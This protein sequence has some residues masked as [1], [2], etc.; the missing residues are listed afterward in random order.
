MRITR[1]LLPIALS[2]LPAAALTPPEPPGAPA[3]ESP[4]SEAERE[5]SEVFPRPAALEPRVRF[6]ARV[7][8]E[9][10]TDGGLLH[11]PDD[12]SLVYEVVR[13]PGVS[14]GS[15][16]RRVEQAK[17]RWASVLRSLASGKR[18]R[19]TPDEQ[20]ALSLFPPGVTSRR[21]ADAAR[22]VRFQLGQADK[23]RAGIVRSGAWEGYIR[24]VLREHGV[25]EPLA[26]LPHVESSFNPAAHSHAGAAGIWQFTRGTGRRFLRI[27]YV[28]DERRD[29]L[30]A[31]VAAARLLREN[32]EITGTWPLAITAYNHGAAGMRRAVAKLGTRDIGAIVERYHS[33]SFG[34]ASQNFYCEFLAA[35][36]VSSRFADHFGPLRRDP[37]VD[38]EVV[39]LDAHYAPATL[40]S[41]FGVSLEALRAANPAL[42]APVW[43][44]SKYVPAGYGLRVPPDPARP[45]G[46]QVLAA[47]DPAQRGAEQRPDRHYRV[48]RG[49]TLSKVAHRFGVSESE[50][51]S[52]NGLR[53][54]HRLQ[55]G[56]LLRL[57][58]D[59]EPGPAAPSQPPPEEG[60]YRVQRGDTLERIARRFGASEAELVRLNG[61]RD[62]HS[63]QAGQVLRLSGEPA[64]TPAP[65]EAAAAT[66]S[67]RVRAG[68]SLSRIAQRHGVSVRELAELN[69]LRDRH[70]LRVGQ[71]L[72][73]PAAAAAP[74]GAP[75]P[76]QAALEP[77]AAPVELASATP[78]A[79]QA[80]P[81]APS[82]PA[83]PAPAP[84]AP[85]PKP[86]A[87]AVAKGIQLDP[88][89]FSVDP[90]GSIRVQ[91]EE[92]LGHYAEW[93][94]VPTQRLRHRNR[95]HS[96]RAIALG[97]RVA[98]DLSRVSAQ[99]FERRR[100]DFHR[101]LVEGFFRRHRVVG[102]EDYV[103]E[104]GD[105][106]WV[107]SQQKLAIP[108]WL[109][110]ALNPD[111]DFGAPLRVGQR[112]R[113]PR[114]EPLQDA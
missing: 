16:E 25:P 66:A 14:E 104:S 38:H 102:T 30:L 4:G 107:L 79:A 70:L 74:P 103:L 58:L 26:A 13:Y 48:H 6:W 88:L 29:P 50:L 65:P 34:F 108:V 17:R 87:P 18:E 55:V 20:H 51:A 106:L 52:L 84:Q 69:G 90:E 59:Q 12:L 68:D 85:A 76:A 40:A 100:L 54:R 81:P 64:Q 73:V 41:A 47:I 35:L 49:D 46:A 80:D 61:L 10:G 112:L 71:T 94:E 1:I 113:V 28:M 91:P 19:L 83:P 62:R 78:A 105:T 93:L 77:A 27:D 31:T 56:Q 11:D 109:L 95:I 110:S 24:R 7:Y 96:D 15:R 114:V 36:D 111:V 42:L 44:G 97:R 5:P 60:R 53:S 3:A 67:Y 99:E 57:P 8:S 86:P 75:V 22:R 43:E 92:T 37:P 63:L 2:A 23:F 32:Y 89:R 72:R 101:E 9:V 82:P 45:A 21:L 98:L 39:T 33:R